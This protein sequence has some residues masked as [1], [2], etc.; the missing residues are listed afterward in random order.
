MKQKDG[1]LGLGPK[2]SCEDADQNKA[3]LQKLLALDFHRTADGHHGL[4][5]DAK[6]R[7]QV[8]LKSGG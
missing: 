2:V 7:L 3:S 8:F 6:S 1:S 5:L 4:T